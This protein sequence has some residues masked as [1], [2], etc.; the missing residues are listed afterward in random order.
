MSLRLV[1]QFTPVSVPAA[2]AGSGEPL[3]PA[4]AATMQATTSRMTLADQ[5][6]LY[7]ILTQQQG[8]K[9]ALQSDLFSATWTGIAL[10]L[11]AGIAGVY[12]YHHFAGR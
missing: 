2:G 9:A 12:A 3:S 4:A 11:F 8:G 5:V 10:G 1:A 6:A 7:G